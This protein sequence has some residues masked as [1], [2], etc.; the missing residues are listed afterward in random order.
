MVVVLLL[1]LLWLS[2]L[3]SM[4]YGLH[5]VQTRSNRRILRF[6][7]CVSLRDRHFDRHLEVCAERMLLT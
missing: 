7:V 6:C 3:S 5:P 1:L 2:S 4:G